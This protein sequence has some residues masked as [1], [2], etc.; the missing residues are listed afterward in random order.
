MVAATHADLKKRVDEGPFRPDLY[1]QLSVAVLQAAPLRERREDIATLASHFV[2]KKARRDQAGPL[3]ISPEAMG[4]LAG[5]DWPG[6]VAEL[7][8]VVEKAAMQ[9]EGD[10]IEPAHLP[11]LSGA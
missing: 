10:A 1:Y 2:Q 8:S 9:C 11:E 5:H 6:N 7:A 3:K 4:T